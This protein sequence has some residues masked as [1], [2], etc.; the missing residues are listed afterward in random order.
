MNLYSL[1][2]TSSV[3]GNHSIRIRRDMWITPSGTPRYI[4]RASDLVRIDLV[5]GEV[6]GRKTPSMEH[7]LHRMIYASREDIKAVVHTYS[8][9]TIGVAI[10]VDF[11][12]VIEEAKIVVGD[13]AIIEIGPLD[14]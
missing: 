12:H 10:S 11:V 3:S 7:N 14:L 4:L 5:T 13:P 2:L 6:K 8:P 1:G 9:Y